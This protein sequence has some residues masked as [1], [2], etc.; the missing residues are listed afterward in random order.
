MVPHHEAL[1]LLRRALIVMADP[2]LGLAL[3]MQDRITHRGGLALG[4]MGSSTLGAAMAL[5]RRFPRSSGYL[6]AVRDERSATEHS[7]VATAG[8][9]EHDVEAYLVDVLFGGHLRLSRLITGGARCSPL[10]RRACPSK[11]GRHY[12]ARKLLRMPRGLWRSSQ[13]NGERDR[14]FGHPIA[15]GE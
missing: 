7:L 2:E 4:M 8:P 11:A 1:T 10:R 12:R 15:L 14:S 13:P 6:L 5:T 9:G 3:G